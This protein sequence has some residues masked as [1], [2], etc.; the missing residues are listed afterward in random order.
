MGDKLARGLGLTKTS[1]IK[2]RS[3][4]LDAHLEAARPF[5][6]PPKR[7]NGSSGMP[8]YVKKG[9]IPGNNAASP[10]YNIDLSTAGNRPNVGRHI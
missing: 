9:G 3:D 7:G 1:W 8:K 6:T 2:P 4:F 10:C 5:K